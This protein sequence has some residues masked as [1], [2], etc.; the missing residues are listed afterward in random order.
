[1]DGGITF[2]NEMMPWGRAGYLC[3][4]SKSV[5]SAV[6]RGLRAPPRKQ[7][8]VDE[9]LTKDAQSRNTGCA[10]RQSPRTCEETNSVPVH[11]STEGPHVTAVIPLRCHKVV[12]TYSEDGWCAASPSKSRHRRNRG[13]RLW[14]ATDPPCLPYSDACRS[15]S[16]HG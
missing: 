6:A 2:Y 1:M 11:T 10:W 14:A 13:R 16:R 4:W 3:P 8:H 9:L 12:G 15:P 5:G 7:K